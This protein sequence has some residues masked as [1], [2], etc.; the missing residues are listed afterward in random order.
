MLKFNVFAYRMTTLLCLVFA[1]N[2]GLIEEN[3][4]RD[5]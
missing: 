3:S 5:L 1:L 2:V 4:R